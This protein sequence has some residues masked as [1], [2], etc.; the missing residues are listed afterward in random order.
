[1][2]ELPQAAHRDRLGD[3]V[4]LAVTPTAQQP[5]TRHR[6]LLSHRRVRVAVWRARLGRGRVKPNPA[7]YDR[8][9][10]QQLDRLGERGLASGTAK[11]ASQLASRHLAK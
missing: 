2:W 5:A 8:F 6:Q 3:A 9:C 7:R 10:W 4:G 1:M 11:I